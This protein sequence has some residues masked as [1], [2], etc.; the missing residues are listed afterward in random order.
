MSLTTDLRL[1]ASAVEVQHDMLERLDFC[2][3]AYLK[4][5]R[6]RDAADKRAKLQQLEAVLNMVTMVLAQ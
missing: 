6:G 5:N 3:R 1:I 2:T 4:A